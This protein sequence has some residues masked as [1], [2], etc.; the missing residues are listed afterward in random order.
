MDELINHPAVQ[1]GAAP[2]LAGLLAVGL[3]YRARLGGLAVVAGFAAAVALISG[4]GFTPLTA[5]RK[6]VLLGLLAPLLG[7]GVDWFSK[8][9][10]A[11]IAILTVLSAASAV[12]V[13]WAVLAQK[14]FADALRLGAIVAVSTAVS[15]ALTLSL[16]SRPVRVAG[17]GLCLGLGTGVAAVLAASTQYGQ[18]GIA[19]GAS[20]GAVLLL[21]M[22][23]G[24]SIPTG[25][26]FAL[27]ASLLCAL[28]GSAAFV[29]ASL[30]WPA[31]TLLALVPL[32][33]RVPLPARTPVWLQAILVC[34]FAMLPAMAAFYLTWTAANGTP[35]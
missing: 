15:V 18:Y 11:V 9:T 32:A 19:I 14:E 4:F 30:P 12:W 33:A 26:T 7:L 35:G 25:A 22:L 1:A 8:P 23:L 24:R 16:V 3:L 17:A 6:I 20:C 29:L 2:F 27:S 13:F 28:L 21:Q 31:L 34:I 5:T 10:R